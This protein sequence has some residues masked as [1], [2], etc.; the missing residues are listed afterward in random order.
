MGD[1][2]NYIHAKDIDFDSGDVTFTEYV[3]KLNTHQFKSC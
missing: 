1:F 3:Y 2:E